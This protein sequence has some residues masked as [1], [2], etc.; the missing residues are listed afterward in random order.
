MDD[1]WENGIYLFLIEYFLELKS[2][3]EFQRKI[4]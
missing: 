2:S 4:N 1:G 3:T